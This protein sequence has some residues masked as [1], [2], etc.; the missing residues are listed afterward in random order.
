MKCTEV[1]TLACFIF[2]VSYSDQGQPQPFAR[3]GGLVAPRTSD[4][5]VTSPFTKQ[6][7]PWNEM[8]LRVVMLNDNSH[9]GEG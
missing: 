2:S 4:Y 7:G 8:L 3:V 9:L 1:R 6:D 5:G